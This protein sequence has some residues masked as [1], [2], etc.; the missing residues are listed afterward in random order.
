VNNIYDS[1]LVRSIGA[2]GKLTELKKRAPV[3]K[4]KREPHF[5]ENEQAVDQVSYVGFYLY[6]LVAA[7]SVCSC[8][9]GRFFPHRD[10]ALIDPN[11]LFV[12]NKRYLHLS[13]ESPRTTR[14]RPRAKR[15]FA[16]T[17]THVN[18]ELSEHNLGHRLFQHVHYSLKP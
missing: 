4:I 15:K 5:L 7:A 6:V 11:H 18:L 12:P 9:Y 14:P 10:G 3:A 13:C 17:R 2:G 16:P 8:V 1:H